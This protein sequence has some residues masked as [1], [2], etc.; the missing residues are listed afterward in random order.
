MV[1]IWIA[2]ESLVGLDLSRIKTLTDAAIAAV[3]AR[4]ADVLSISVAPAVTSAG[5]FVL[6]VVTYREP[7][8]PRQ[9]A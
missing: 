2:A 1:W 4:G 8:A 9:A 7:D 5:A 3:Q 6:V